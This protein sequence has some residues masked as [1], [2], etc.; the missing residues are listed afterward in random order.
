MKPETAEIQEINQKLDLIIEALG[1]NR[2][3]KKSNRD[4]DDWVK[5]V[6]IDLDKK[7]RQPGDGSS[8]AC[9]KRKVSDRHPT[10]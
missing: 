6:V 8:R 10:G 7:R 4:I 5:S 2:K 9:K 3:P 1:L